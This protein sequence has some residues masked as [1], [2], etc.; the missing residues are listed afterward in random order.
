MKPMRNMGWISMTIWEDKLGQSWLFPPCI[1]DFISEDHICHLVIGIID[2]MDLSS[3]EEKY[4]GTPGNPAYPPRMMLR[5]LIQASIDGEFSSREIDRLV[6]ENVVYMFLAGNERPDFRTFC[7]FRRDNKELIESLF[8]KTVHIA[9]SMNVL[10]LKHLS[11]DGTIIK[12]N[13][14]KNNSLTKEELREIKRIIEK[15]IEI[16]EM[17]DEL[18][19]DKRG[20]KLPPD[21]NTRKKIQDKIKEIEKKEDKKLKNAAK[22]VLAQFIIGDEK[23][24]KKIIK[25]IETAEKEIVKS[26]QK[27]V[28]LT[29]PEARFMMNRK[30]RYEVS[31]NPQITV[32]NESGIIVANDVVQACNDSEQLIPMAEKTKKNLDGLPTNAKMSWDNGY[33]SGPNLKYLEDKEI[34]GYIPDRDLAKRMKSKIDDPYSKDKFRYD[35]TRDVFI[36][37]EGTILE[38]KGRH[39]YNGRYKFVYYSS[40]CYS[41][42]S[43]KQC[44]KKSPYKHIYSD[45]FE[46]ER[47]RMIAKMQSEQGKEEYGKRKET[48]EWPFGNIKYNLGFR[49]F[50]T[51]G[52]GNV[53]T[54]FNLVCIAHNLIVLWKK[55]ERDLISLRM[56]EFLI[57][58][59]LKSC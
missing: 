43:R 34:D 2:N 45:G 4:I 3:I 50:R 42:P 36:C 58:N 55:I 17:E 12:A 32:D 20:D 52:T 11:T 1:T 13:A 31:F 27:A 18:Y 33:N 30:H 21:L 59:P 14:S 28:S 16:D 29:D 9:K 40:Q 7:N 44:A 56:K 22:N 5:V 23:R 53:K 48:V 19:G 51:R 54:E 26:G 35:E 10:V 25:R 57:S 15:G 46:L 49:E 24:K 37:P 6:C 47:K 38:K 39:K 8:Q 41:C